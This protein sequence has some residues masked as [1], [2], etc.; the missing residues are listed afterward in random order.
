MVAD[1]WV[2][3]HRI[4]LKGNARSKTLADLSYVSR[5]T[6]QSEKNT[7]VKREDGDLHIADREEGGTIPWR[8]L[9]D[10]G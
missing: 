8:M 5:I 7:A 4:N 6:D 10:T 9:C 2:C 1:T 3:D